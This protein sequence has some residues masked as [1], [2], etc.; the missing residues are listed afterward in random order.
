[1]SEPKFQVAVIPV[2]PYQQNCSLIWSTA[3]KNGAVIDPGGDVP[4]IE[5]AIRKYGVKVE[6]II[7][8]HG[9]VD[10]AAG[11]KAL[12]DKLGVPVIG[13]HRDDQFLLDGLATYGLQIG[14][15]EARN[16]TPDQYLNEGDKVT[17]ADIEFSV[18]HVPGHT[19]GHVVLLSEENDFALVG[20]VVFENSVGRTDFK[21]YGNTQ[22][23]MDGIAAKLLPLKDSTML[24]PGHGN[25]T[26]IGQERR[27]NP[28]LI[29]L[30]KRQAV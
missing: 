27:N 11:A 12:A 4:L 23:L 13:P 2:T 5:E 28:F 9:H 29:K 6:K 21:P 8:T 15:N 17:I 16:V 30:N 24:L 19:P 22:Q 7:L 10:H 3:T 20:D 14:I 25:M 26:T 1:M 18:L